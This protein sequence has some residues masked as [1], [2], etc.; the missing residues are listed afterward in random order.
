MFFPERL[1]LPHPRPQ[2]DRASSARPPSAAWAQEYRATVVSADLE[3]LPRLLIHVRRTQHAIFVLHRGVATESARQFAAPVPP[4]RLHNLARRLIQNAVVVSLQPDANSFFSNHASLSL[5]PPA[6]RRRKELAAELQAAS[7]LL[8]VERRHSCPLGLQRIKTSR[9][10]SARAHV[11]PYCTISE[12]VPALPCVPLRESQKRKALLHRHRRRDQLDHQAHV[13]PGIT[14]SVPAGSSA[15]P[16][17][18]VV[19]K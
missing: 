19:R 10:E 9:A 2:A 13:V 5:T 11:F 12:I 7:Y 18:S 8:M 3:L 14:I 17:T 1:N 16:V 6:F 15:T 4:C